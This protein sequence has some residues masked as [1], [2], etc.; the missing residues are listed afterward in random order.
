VTDPSTIL[1]GEG[2]TVLT[3]VGLGV[4]TDGSA[5]TGY[6]GSAGGVSVVVATNDY[7]AVN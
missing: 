7:Y 2:S 5:A 4:S 6:G 1:P 3:D